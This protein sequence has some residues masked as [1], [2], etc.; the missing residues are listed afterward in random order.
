M[1][2]IDSHGE[3]TRVSLQRAAR[4]TACFFVENLVLLA[5][6]QQGLHHALDLFSA[7][8]EQS[9]NENQH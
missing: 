7:V 8:C 1:N 4:S 5:S 9:R 2:W 6:S 3:S